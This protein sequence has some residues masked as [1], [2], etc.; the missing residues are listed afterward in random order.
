MS[1]TSTKSVP[2]KQIDGDVAVGRNVTAGG[3]ANIQGGARVGHNLKVEGWLDAPNLRHPN[4][5]MY[6]SGDALKEAYPLP[7]KGWWAVVGTALPGKIWIE[8]DGEWIATET[9]GP[10]CDVNISEWAQEVLVLTVGPEI[11]RIDG[12]IGG[13]QNSLNEANADIEGLEADMVVLDSDITDLGE[14]LRNHIAT[15]ESNKLFYFDREDFITGGSSDPD[16]TIVWDAHD[17]TFKVSNGGSW[18]MHPSYNREENMKKVPRSDIWFVSP[19]GLYRIV[20][21]G[22]SYVLDRVLDVE[23]AAVSDVTGTVDEV[24]GLPYY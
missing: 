14:T 20:K 2:T 23:A 1:A 13:L 4:K 18:V 21:S 24:L 3:D 22:D 15:A 8:K 16:G 6:M 10:A 9:D 19:Q 11:E 12:A 17:H 7:Q 5:G